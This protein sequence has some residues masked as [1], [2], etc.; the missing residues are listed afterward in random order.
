M[1]SAIQNE[2]VFGTRAMLRDNLLM[3]RWR[4]RLRLHE[5]YDVEQLAEIQ[6]RMLHATLQ[7]AI[8]RLPYYAGLS[9]DFSI[10]EAPQ[11]L[12]EQF[13]IISKPTLL[14]NRAGLYPHGG[15]RYPWET[16]GMTSGTTGSPLTIYRSLTSVLAEQ[17]FIKRH[18]SWIGYRDGMTRATLRGDMVVDLARTEPPFWFWNRY[19]H[20]LV[21][22]SRH[23][24]DAHAGYLIDKLAQLRPAMMQAYPSTAFAL[25]GYLA[26]SGRQLDIP[27]V[28]TASEPTYGHQRELISAQLNC[29]IVDMYGMAER[30]AF[31]TECEHGSL[32]LN[33]DYSYVEILDDSGQSTNDYGYVV[34]TTF[35]N[36][37]MPLV[38][39]QLSDRTR[40]KPGRCTCGRHFPMI[41]SVTGKVEDAIT[42]SHGKV[43]SPSVLTFAFKGV[44]NIRKS[45]VAQIAPA[46]W[47]IRVVADGEFSTRE[48]DLLIGNIRKFVD[49]EVEV[50]I[51]MREDLPNTKAGKFSWVVN[52]MAV[53]RRES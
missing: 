42:G 24:T 9:A 15:K 7:T 10:S 8:R 36:Q 32:H 4:Q 25:A 21:M 34:G 2:L 18:W 38:R 22:S 37:L 13:P 12:R 20:Q 49:A 26:R 28:L 6:N 41:E 44:P 30:V 31:A 51:V 50:R 33:P 1:P 23:L 52:E 39:Y 29:Q 3:R 43:I 19:D 48:S 14:A 5:S 53:R 17:A 16:S 46:C 11:V 40:W 27:Y 47:E 45:Q 35:H